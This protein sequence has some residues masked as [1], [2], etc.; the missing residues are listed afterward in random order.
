M[1]ELSAR[2]EETHV[3]ISNFYAQDFEAMTALV[4]SHCSSHAQWVTL[5]NMAIMQLLLLH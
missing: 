1:I 5:S 4:I 3:P 2:G